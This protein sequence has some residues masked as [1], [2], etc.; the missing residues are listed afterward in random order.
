MNFLTFPHALF[1][2]KAR[3]MEN[4]RFPTSLW[5]TPQEFPT[6]P[7]NSIYLINFIWYKKREL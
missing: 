1:C 7:Q 4:Q 2:G 5:K 6:F 3:D